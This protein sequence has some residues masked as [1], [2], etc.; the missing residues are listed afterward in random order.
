ML[1]DVLCYILLPFTT[2]LSWKIFNL[3]R[4][5]SFCLLSGTTETGFFNTPISSAGVDNEQHGEF[6]EDS[7]NEAVTDAVTGGREAISPSIE[8][9]S[10]VG[11]SIDRK[12]TQHTSVA[13]GCRVRLTDITTVKDLKHYVSKSKK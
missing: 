1:V 2:F 3:F 13:K 6:E 12:R 11:K 7:E 8:S 5:A 4:V 10:P 9:N